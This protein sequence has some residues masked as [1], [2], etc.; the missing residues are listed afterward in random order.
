MSTSSFRLVR[1]SFF[2]FL[3]SFFFTAVRCSIFVYPKGGQSL[4]FWIFLNSRIA[5]FFYVSLG[6]A[7]G[8]YTWI[9][10]AY[11]FGAIMTYYELAEC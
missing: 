1:N 4:V 6:T 5:S 10:T 11:A 9:R 7:L 2:P 3:K 8:W